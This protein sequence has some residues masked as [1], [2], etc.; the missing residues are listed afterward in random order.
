MSFVRLGNTFYASPPCHEIE[1]LPKTD[2][3]I[4]KKFGNQEKKD[5]PYIKLGI[6]ISIM[7]LLIIIHSTKRKNNSEKISTKTKFKKNIA[8][9]WLVL[10]L[11][12][13]SSIILSYL[14]FS[15]GYSDDDYFIIFY[16]Y[17]IVQILRSL[18]WAI[19]TVR[20]WNWTITGSSHTSSSAWPQ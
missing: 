10:F 12:F 15:M 4:E 1:F 5:I 19:K 8:K 18:I 2:S 3:Q 14:L 20:K 17:I 11:S 9:E 13:T 6:F 7:Y 16:P